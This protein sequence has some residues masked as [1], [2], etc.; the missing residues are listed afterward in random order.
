MLKSTGQTRTFGFKATASVFILQCSVHIDKSG[1]QEISSKRGLVAHA[2]NPSTPE[3]EQAD[4]CEFQASQLYGV[5][6]CHKKGKHQKS[7]ISI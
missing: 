6:P 7:F 1:S 4:L 3:L 5:R 2:F